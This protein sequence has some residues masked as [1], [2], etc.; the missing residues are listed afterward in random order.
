[1]RDWQIISSKYVG[2]Y[3]YLKFW[4]CQDCI[5]Y[6]YLIYWYLTQRFPKFGAQENHLGILNNYCPLAPTRLYR[7]WLNLKCGMGRL[8]SAPSGSKVHQSL[9]TTA[10]VSGSWSF[11]MLFFKAG[12]WTNSFSTRLEMLSVPLQTYWISLPLTKSPGG[13]NALSSA[14]SIGLGSI[15]LI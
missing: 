14:R 13:I 9:K 6:G 4:P 15:S 11:S 1:M 5:D 2:N 7:H 10:L 3:S 12:P 8:Q